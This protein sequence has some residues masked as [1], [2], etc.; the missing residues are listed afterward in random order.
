MSRFQNCSLSD[1]ADF[2][3]QPDSR[4]RGSPEINAPPPSLSISLSDNTLIVEENRSAADPRGIC[5]RRFHKPLSRRPPRS[6]LI[7]ESQRCLVA[8]S[9][10]SFRFQTRP[11]GTQPK[12]PIDVLLLSPPRPL[13]CSPPLPDLDHQLYFQLPRPLPHS[14]PPSLPH[15]SIFHFQRCVLLCSSKPAAATLRVIRPVH[16]LLR[17]PIMW[18]GKKKG[19]RSGC[20]G[21]LLAG[22]RT[23]A[24][25]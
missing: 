12:A 2:S 25:G 8:F 4:V 3:S 13:L 17:Q 19:A 18:R 22:E 9:A 6:F 15:L 5:P 10:L 24:F 23:C 20:A 21:A 7:H 16:R 1:N 14:L 11:L